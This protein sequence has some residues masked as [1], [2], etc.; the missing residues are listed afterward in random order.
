M[1][2]LIIASAMRRADILDDLENHG[3]E[4]MEALCQLYLY[5]DYPEYRNHWR[6]EVWNHYKSI[7]PVKKSHKYPKIQDIYKYIWDYNKK[8]FMWCVEAT[9]AH[10]YKLVPNKSRL[11]N[12]DS[13]Y[14]IMGDYFSWVSEKLSKFGEIYPSE[15]YKK[16]ESLGL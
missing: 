14:A 11:D 4:C 1:K 2:R 10:E 16:L 7:H 13:L 3:R 12:L 6:T 15:C 5:T 8:S 9:Q